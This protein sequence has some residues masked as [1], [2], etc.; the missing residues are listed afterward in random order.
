MYTRY[1]C[2]GVPSLVFINKD[3]QEIDRIVG[4]R[5]PSDYLNSIKK[6]SSNIETFFSLR[7]QYFSGKHSI[8]LLSMLAN[9][10]DQQSKLDS[11]NILYNKLST[12]KLSKEMKYEVEYFKSKYQLSKN[13]DPSLITDYI[14]TYTG[15]PYIKK[16]FLR[17]I[18]FFRIQEN[19]GFEIKTY[20][21]AISSFPN[22]YSLLNRYA[23]R[24]TE[25]GANLVD[26]LNKS[27]H[28]IS[29]IEDEKE[30]AMVIDTK[31][32]ILWKLNRF[33]ESV[34]EIDKALRIDP[35]NSYYIK[36][37]S[38]FL[39]SLSKKISSSI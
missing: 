23:W 3:G 1:Q 2:K 29:L 32:E 15:S 20:V 37:K 35:E 22:D 6:I 5:E 38:K 33:E 10:Y 31:A 12:Y 4:F 39:N 19:K 24:M 8:E 27:S 16:A 26:A 30:K 25:L 34:D 28:A 18:S 36:Q 9:K 17:K 7:N 21:E 11:A 13:N 14:N